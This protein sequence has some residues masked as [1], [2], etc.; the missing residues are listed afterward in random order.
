[1]PELPD[2]ELYRHAI[3]ERVVG[4]PLVGVKLFSPFVLRTVTPLVAAVTGQ[5]I[6]SVSRL[7]KRIVLDMEG[8]LHVVVHLMIAGRLLWAAG[9]PTV[10]QPGG[11]NTLAL[12]QFLQGHILLT[13]AGTKRR[14]SI[15]VVDSDGLLA[16]DPGGIEPLDSTLDAFVKALTPE[17]H[18]IKRALTNPRYV[19][20]IGNAYSDEIFHAAHLSPIRLTKSMT[21]EEWARLH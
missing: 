9:E 1:M 17:N 15:H 8:G 21:A 3:A 19:A 18:T 2:I 10:R 11:R 13:E 5:R 20:G 14:A 12:F 4:G 7:G 16:L 6:D